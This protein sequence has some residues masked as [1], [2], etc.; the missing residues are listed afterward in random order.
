MFE[1]TGTVSVIFSVLLSATIGWQAAQRIFPFG[2]KGTGLDKS[3][4]VRSLTKDSTVDLTASAVMNCLTIVWNCYIIISIWFDLGRYT[5]TAILYLILVVVALLLGWH[6][7]ALIEIIKRQSAERKAAAAEAKRNR[8]NPVA[9][10]T[11]LVDSADR[12]SD[13]QLSL[14]PRQ[15]EED[16]FFNADGSVKEQDTV[17]RLSA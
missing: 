13:R 6:H 12:E 7:R 9:P 8:K 14:P 16:S 2:L 10:A 11:T 3:K 17:D 4:K 1:L 5:L 15:S